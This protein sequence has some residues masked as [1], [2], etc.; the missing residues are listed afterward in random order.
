MARQLQLEMSYKQKAYIH[1]KKYANKNITKLKEQAKY[2]LYP[3]FNNTHDVQS[4]QGNE[5]SQNMPV[6][7]DNQNANEQAN[8]SGWDN[9][10][11]N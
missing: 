5:S 10:K 8:R 11:L 1:E 3:H 6:I 7:S 9:Q 2:V 4:G